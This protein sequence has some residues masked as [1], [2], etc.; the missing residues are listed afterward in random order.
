VRSTTIEINLFGACIVRSKTGAFEI[1]SA[2]H[3]AIFVMLATA[4]HGR[5]TR[6]FL[7]EMLWGTSCHDT[8]RQSL[9]RALS[10]IKQAM[11]A[12]FT[13]CF[14]INNT[15]IGININK[16]HFIGRPGG[17][18]FLEGI[19]IRD[20]GFNQWLNGVRNNP[21]QI[22]SLY[23]LAAQKPSKPVQPVIAIL[24]FQALLQEAS[25]AVLG[26]WLAEEIA[27]TLSRSTLLSVISH[28]SSRRAAGTL[29]DLSM[30]ADR[31]GADFCMCG[32]LREVNGKI[33]LDADFIDV[34]SGRILWTRQFSGQVGTFYNEKSEPLAELVKAIGHAIA[35]DS[36]AQVKAIP[37]PH[38]ED[39]HLL[40]AG[41][42]LLHE[43]RIADFARSRQLLE[44]IIRRAPQ[45][46]EAH[47]W[48]GEWHVMLIFNGWSTDRATNT[49]MARDC[50][51]RALDID[52]ENAFCMTIDGVVH[53]N[54][55][56]R[57]DDAESRFTK[58]LEFNPNEAM[59]WL[60]SG[61]LHGYR[62]EGDTAVERVEKSLKLSPMD[63][64]DH[65]YESLA[66]SAHISNG[67]FER[68]FELAS[69]SFAV[70]DRHLSTLRAKIC[71][72]VNMGRMDEAQSDA[73]LLLA[74][75]PTFNIRDYL[76]GHPAAN[77][78]F[79]TVHAEALAMAGLPLEPA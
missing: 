50:T 40:I 78:K 64:F 27:R 66:A 60:F 62:D 63:P 9:R 58:A 55:L 44:E 69:R 74:R 32:R 30:V 31:L 52:P 47:A 18:E 1:T 53:N 68:A 15:E 46:A 34:H 35:T 48:L 28:L 26:D 17:A 65:F 24:P 14:V 11:G 41:V 10:D 37:L 51:A 57:L 39:R 3:K 22:F 43:L 71:A 67:N 72:L 42:S 4:P 76:S 12:E 29:I 45:T 38:L 16:V 77:F 8:G 13:A 75:Q 59:A 2:K 21:S 54:L 61:V 70:N 36:L 23:G 79:G 25:H 56:M 49:Q 7:Q 6:A 73:R 33:R 5:R 20:N 19:D